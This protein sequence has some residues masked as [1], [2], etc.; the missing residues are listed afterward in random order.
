LKIS[1][2]LEQ[3]NQDQLKV[4]LY[5]FCSNLVRDHFM[6][7]HPELA[8][9]MKRVGASFTN[10]CPLMFA[11]VPGIT[12]KE[13]FVTNSNKT[14]VYSNSRFFKDDAI[15]EIVVSGEIPPDA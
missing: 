3:R 12:E 13:F 4:P 7:E 5:L 11:G 15:L 8:M 10:T 2:A 14:R 1:Q 6:D 9:R